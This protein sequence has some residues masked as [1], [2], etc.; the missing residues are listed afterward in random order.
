MKKST[1]PAAD[2][3]WALI[4]HEKRRDRFLRKVSVTAWSVTI[5]IVLLF[6]VM[7]GLQVSETMSAVA[8]GAVPRGAIVGAAMPL[9]IVLGMLAILIA[10]LSTVGIFLRLRTTSLSEIQLR[11]AALE[12]ILASRPD[13]QT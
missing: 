9:I 7:I 12:D 4:E 1:S 6:A 11:L 2:E 8:V 10:T 13:P 3:A 5:A